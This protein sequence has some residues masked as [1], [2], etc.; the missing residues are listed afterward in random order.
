[1]L[2]LHLAATEPD[3]ALHVEFRRSVER[4]GAVAGQL[5]LARLPIVVIDAD[6]VRSQ[7]SVTRVRPGTEAEIACQAPLIIS[8]SSVRC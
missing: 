3:A 1:V 4:L 8:V 7:P 2:W 5:G 6:I